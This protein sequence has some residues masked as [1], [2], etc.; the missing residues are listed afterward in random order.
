MAR[1]GGE[2]DIGANKEVVSKTYVAGLEFLKFYLFDAECF[3]MGRRAAERQSGS[4]PPPLPVEGGHED[5]VYGRRRSMLDGIMRAID[6]MHALPDKS[7][8]ACSSPR[9]AAT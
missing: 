3:Y 1:R 8:T 5:D 9:S 7:V 2:R 4:P 6:V